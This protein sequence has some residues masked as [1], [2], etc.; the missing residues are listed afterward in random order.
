M[1]KEEIYSL[2]MTMKHI[3]LAINLLTTRNIDE[4]QEGVLIFYNS[5]KYYLEK[6]KNMKPFMVELENGI[7]E[8][9]LGEEDLKTI[10]AGE[11]I[12]N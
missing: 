5:L 3:E 11:K 9:F 10:G 6:Y 2:E 8:L 1:K 12:K 7:K 4:D